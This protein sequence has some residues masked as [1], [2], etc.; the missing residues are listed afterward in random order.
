MGKKTNTDP[1][2]DALAE[3]LELPDVIVTP[4]E[5]EAVEAPVH[6]DAFDRPAFRRMEPRTAA[7]DAPQRKRPTPVR[8]ANTRMAASG[9]SANPALLSF[10][11]DKWGLTKDLK[12]AMTQLGSRVAGDPSK[13]ALA[14]AVLKILTDHL[15]LKYK[16]DREYRERVQARSEV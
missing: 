11:T 7:S 12:R 6:N 14:D 4:A 5:P 9:V 10:P 13:K 8:Q 16:S 15:E 3:Q 2:L 1:N